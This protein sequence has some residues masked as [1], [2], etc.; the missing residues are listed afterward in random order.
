MNNNYKF[1]KT[2]LETTTELQLTNYNK[3]LFDW[4]NYSLNNQN[5]TVKW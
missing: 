4:H 3:S 2:D 5:N 1:N